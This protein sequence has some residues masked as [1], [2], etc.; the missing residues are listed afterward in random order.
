LNYPLST[1]KILKRWLRLVDRFDFSLE[2]EKKLFPY[3]MGDDISAGSFIGK[4]T[5][6]ILLILKKNL[7]LA[8]FRKL[9]LAKS[10]GMYRVE[11]K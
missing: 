9:I 5:Y 6:R 2:S 8:D 3:Q 4:T 7:D 10:L 11:I 1:F